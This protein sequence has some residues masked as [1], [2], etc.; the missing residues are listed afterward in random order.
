VYNAIAY[1]SIVIG[2]LALVA[3]PV[4]LFGS[5]ILKENNH[6]INKK[7]HNYFFVL[8][9]QHARLNKIATINFDP[10]TLRSTFTG[11]AK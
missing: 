3:F 10:T 2:A 9:M 6:S 11:F 4:H 7:Q 8:L 5:A 1:F